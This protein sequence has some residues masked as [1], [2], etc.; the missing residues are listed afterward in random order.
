MLLL[1][2]LSLSLASCYLG[3]SQTSQGL[4][5]ILVIF[6]SL[7]LPEKLGALTRRV[8]LDG[9]V[10]CTRHIPCNPRGSSLASPRSMPLVQN[11]PGSQIPRLE[12]AYVI[13]EH[14]RPT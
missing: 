4:S 7:Y 12:N 9:W 3:L 13:C 6:K 11:H 14:R 2:V 1:L 8:I 10:S 5:D